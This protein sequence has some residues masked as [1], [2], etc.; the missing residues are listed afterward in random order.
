LFALQGRFD[1]GEWIYDIKH[2]GFRAL[3]STDDAAWCR[4]KSTSYPASE[5]WQMRVEVKAG[6]AIL[7]GELV[8]ADHF[9]R[10]LRGVLTRFLASREPFSLDAIRTCSVNRTTISW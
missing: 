10:M 8:V 5:T 6:A 3:A 9:G 4:G 7:D 1:P 2:D